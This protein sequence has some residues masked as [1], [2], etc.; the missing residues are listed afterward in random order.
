MSNSAS[1]TSSDAKRHKTRVCVIGA[2]P[3]GL[4]TLRALQS[5][6]PEQSGKVE[7]EGWNPYEVVCYE[8]YAEVG[9]LWNFK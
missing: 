2:G 8:R 5:L 7:E 3:G 6:E 9:G 1:Q 4:M